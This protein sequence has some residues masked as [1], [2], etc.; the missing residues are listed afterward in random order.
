MGG[1]KTKIHNGKK[2]SKPIKIL[3]NGLDLSA[4]RFFFI[5]FFTGVGFN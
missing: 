2:N 4:F 3:T 5:L 1:P